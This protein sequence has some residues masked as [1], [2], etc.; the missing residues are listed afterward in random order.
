M[1]NIIVCDNAKFCESDLIRNIQKNQE[2]YIYSLSTG[3]KNINNVERI[4]KEQGHFV[5]KLKSAALLNKSVGDIRKK[6]IRLIGEIPY[7]VKINGKELRWVFS[8]DDNF[9][10]WW[11][12]IVAEKNPFTTF[13]FNRLCRLDAIIKVV[14]M[15]KIEKVIFISKD[16]VLRAAL[17]V[18][19]K[20]NAMELL[21]V[22]LKERL[23]FTEKVKMSHKGFYVKNMFMMVKVFV[24]LFAR[25]VV[26]KKCL[27]N[28]RNTKLSGE[29]MLF[30]TY[31]PLMDIEKAQKGEFKN[32]YCESL[33][34]ALESQGEIVWVNMYG[35][36]PSV[37]FKE[38]ISYALKF[39]ENG[40]QMY[41]LEQF[42]SV[43]IFIKSF[44]QTILFSI[45]F[46]TV[47]NKIDEKLRWDGYKFY[48]VFKDDF[49]ISLAGYSM[50]KNLIYYYTWQNV[51]K[52]LKTKK[53]F[54]FCEMQGWERALVSARNKVNKDLKLFAYQHGTVSDLYMSYFNDPCETRDYSQYSLPKPD[55]IICNGKSSYEQIKDCGWAEEHL[56]I[57]EA[58]RYY[59]LRDIIDGG[60]SKKNV[61][62]LAFSIDP[63]ES[64]ALLDFVHQS[65]FDRKDVEVW[66]KPHPFLSMKH[67]YMFSNVN[68]S[69]MKYKIYNI[70]IE[71]LLYEAR[72]VVAGQSGVSL[73]AV[74]YGCDLIIINPVEMINVS[75]LRN[76][77]SKFIV[78]VDSSDELVEVVDEIFANKYDYKK[79]E[80]ESK[81]IVEDY[82][83]L[84]EKPG[85]P[86]RI[87]DII[88]KN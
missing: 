84:D 14:Q 46:L 1:R 49:Y 64:A 31:Y 81:E 25:M 74:F 17:Q 66:V 41:F 35:D 87:M 88:N 67:V 16:K 77:K 6:Y 79:H 73:Q 57:G 30:A 76:R 80:K 34:N 20:D 68:E 62:L 40:C 26:A 72:I 24:K 47:Q 42:S 69:D 59:H 60:I 78:N 36:N 9:S 45:R 12:S 86:N 44:F 51:F 21:N 55:K 54:Y 48:E 85:Y 10:L 28:T 7:A 50:L 39:K 19:L 70:P 33:Q 27:S 63:K 75:P 18:Y 38:S 32:K 13:S 11:P 22:K 61:V 23:F 53:C 2:S 8:V 82:F 52:S 56:C 37:S 71:K 4:L 65:F 83:C 58:I 29:E 43:G 15:E 5:V 3:S